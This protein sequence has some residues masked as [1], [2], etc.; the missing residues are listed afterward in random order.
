V[1]LYI[2]IL[3]LESRTIAYVVIMVAE[4]PCRYRYYIHGDYFYSIAL[5]LGV[6]SILEYSTILG[7]AEAIF[8]QNKVLNTPQVPPTIVTARAGE[9][10]GLS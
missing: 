4:A 5:V 9:C 8:G 2:Y 10:G 3:S 1:L 6:I 7:R